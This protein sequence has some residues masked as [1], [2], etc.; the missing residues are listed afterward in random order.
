MKVFISWSGEKSKEYAKAL[1]EWIEQ[2]IQSVEVFFSPDDIE[3]G[4]NWNATLIKELSE[5]NFGIIC[6]TSENVV[7]PW[8]HFEAG[9]ISKMLS[10]K[11][12]VLATDISISEIVGP[13]ST[14]QATKLEKEDLYKLL[15]SINSEI[16]HPLEIKKLEKCFEV[17]YNDFENKISVINSQKNIVKKEKKKDIN[18][19]ILQL[20]REISITIN[21]PQ[22]FISNEIYELLSEKYH[23]GI[24]PEYINREI[25]SFF[26]KLV[27]LISEIDS[28]KYMDILY[29][30][31]YYFSKRIFEINPIVGKQ[32]LVILKKERNKNMH[33][34]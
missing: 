17:F 24:N 30:E 18:E 1:K 29:E 6:L 3:K 20:V 14:Y 27:L 26:K 16:E 2:C 19:E 33:L 34:L 5:T 22:K 8:L 31:F 28:E 23:E 25:I 15:Q 12:A 9:A 7:A 4:T 11:V 32:L 10:S 21:S 13:L